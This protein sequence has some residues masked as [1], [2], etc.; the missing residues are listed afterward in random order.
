M[1]PEASQRKGPNVLLQAFIV[2]EKN[3]LPGM[4]REDSLQGL[5]I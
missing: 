3:D 2:D 4:G 1:T 5:Q